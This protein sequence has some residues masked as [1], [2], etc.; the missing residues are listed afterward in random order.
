MCE[1]GNRE[2]MDVV[3]DAVQSSAKERACSRSARQ[4]HSGARGSAKRK[5]RRGSRR[6]EDCL[7]VRGEGGI[8]DHAIDFALERHELRWIQNGGHVLRVIVDPVEEQPHLDLRGR[9]TNAN[10]DHEAIELLFGQR[11]STREVLGIL[12]G[13]HEERIG[14]RDG[15][16][17][18]R[19]LPLVHRFEQRGLGTRA[20]AVDFVGE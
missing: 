15:L 8:D 3:G 4:V 7:Q 20:C 14:Q 12:R 17:I 5:S 9:I 1:H 19:H 6:N 2:L 11:E 10:P 18:E 13:Q 16:S